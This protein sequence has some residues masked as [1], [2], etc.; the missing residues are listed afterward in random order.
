MAGYNP[1]L[2]YN[3]STGQWLRSIAEPVS[4]NPPAWVYGD[5]K[6]LNITFVRSIGG[7]QIAIVQTITSLLVSVAASR[8]AT[9]ATSATATGPDSAYG[10]TVVLPFDTAGISA[11]ATATGAQAV[12]E[13][14][15]G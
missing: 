7:G 10:F 9:V 1:P 5:T 13:F 2:V 14:F 12:L 15:L 8:G 4:I 6:T 11:I 3:L